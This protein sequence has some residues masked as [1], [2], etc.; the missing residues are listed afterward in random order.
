M[1]T[2]VLLCASARTYL[3]P[4]VDIEEVIIERGYTLSG[5]I[6]DVDKDEEVPFL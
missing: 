3:P 2:K 6:E 5:I 1:V 4:V